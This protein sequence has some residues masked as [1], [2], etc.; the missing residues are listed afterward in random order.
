MVIGVESIDKLAVVFY[1]PAIGNVL[2]FVLW[3]A[4]KDLLAEYLRIAHKVL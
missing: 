4:L 1:F 2:P 3:V